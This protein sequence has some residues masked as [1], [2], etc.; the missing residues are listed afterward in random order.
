MSFGKTH[1]IIPDSH[2]HPDFSNRRYK[3]L[4]KLV[5]DVKPDT[6]VDIGDWADMPSLC[7]YDKG[8]KGY[9]NRRY[10]ADINSALD[11][12]DKFF[13]PIKA[14]KR[15][16]PRFIHHDGNHEQRIKRAISLD[17][18]KLDGTISLKDLEFEERGWEVV[19]YSGNTP[20]INTVDGVNYA[21]FFTSGIMGRAISG[22]RPAHQLLQKQYESCVQG[23]AHITDY[24][25]RTNARGKHIHGLVVGV[26]QDYYSDYAGAA[27][28]LWWRG[29]IVLR[30]VEDGRFNPQWI[31]MDRIRKEYA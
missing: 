8:K 16:L 26:Y 27:N 24:C 29:V 3:W 7:D 23:H 31:S 21:H 10:Q 2:A 4:G 25:I 14:A 20:G 17:E 18:V 22:E 11:A 15:K 12:Q 9:N 6:V 5:A 30:D 1:L 19:P 28:E 13:A